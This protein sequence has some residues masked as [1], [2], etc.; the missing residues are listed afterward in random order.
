VYALGLENAQTAVRYATLSAN[1]AV[2]TWNLTTPLLAARR[3]HCAA[4]S[5][6]HVYVIAGEATNTS[7]DVA[8]INQ[9]GTLGAWQATTPLPQPLENCAA[10]VAL[11]KLHVF[12]GFVG[13]SPVAA[14]HTADIGAAG[15]LGSWTAGQAMTSPRAEHAFASATTTNGTQVFG[16]IGGFS[17]PGTCTASGEWTHARPNGTLAPWAPLPPLPAPARRGAVAAFT[18]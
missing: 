10:A 17:A 14:V 4:A 13:A 6:S 7:V 16:V 3:A 5:D 9:D 18:R 8:P 11:G 1:G 2:G 12:G 15:S